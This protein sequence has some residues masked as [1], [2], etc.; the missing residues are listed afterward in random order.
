MTI[1]LL[2]FLFKI[3]HIFTL[4]PSSIESKQITWFRKLYYLLIFAVLTAGAIS[5]LV[6][7]K[8]HRSSVLMKTVVTTAED[9]SVIAFHFQTTIV[10]NLW[11]AES[12]KNL[13]KSLKVSEYLIKT[14]K[15]KDDR[16]EYLVF[17]GF[18]LL[19]GIT[20]GHITYVS[21]SIPVKQCIQTEAWNLAQR[22]IL[23]LYTFLL[24]VIANMIR[25]RYKGL[26][27]RICSFLKKKSP[28]CDKNFLDFLDWVEST[29]NLLK[30]TVQIYNSLFGGSIFWIIS[31]TTFHI[32]NYT[33]NLLY[34]SS[35]YNLSHLIFFTMFIFHWNFVSLVRLPCSI[36]TFPSSS[37]S[38]LCCSCCVIL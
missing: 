20:W 1:R 21:C 5:N 25:I 13:L 9:F 28:V 22:Y 10:L 16:R 24:C 32:L 11:T 14:K 38:H 36:L 30:N 37:W 35:L 2:S 7:K 18:N 17:I 33:Y 27:L 8:F 3:G 12:W 4:I 19:Y 31:F 26:R 15:T 34:N 29:M 6:L 23:L